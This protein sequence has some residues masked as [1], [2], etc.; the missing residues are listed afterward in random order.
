MGLK[1]QAHPPK[2]PLYT[3]AGD[4]GKTSLFGG[5]RVNK[6]HPR[7]KAYGSL[8]ELSSAL[9]LAAAF[10]RQRRVIGVLRSIQEDL[11]HLGA[12]LASP[13]APPCLLPEDRI[14]ALERLIDRYDAKT[15]PLKR[16]ILPG[17]G[18]AGAALHLARTICRRAERQV[19]ALARQET[20][21]PEVMI[22]LNRLSDLL[23]ALARYVNW[24]EGRPETTWPPGERPPRR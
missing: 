10:V 24:A 7:V 8:D 16:F 13:E 11:F 15:P 22:Y 3:R 23:F 5:Q 17:G 21:R 20:V 12:E 18:P 14:E 1:V 4:D 9:G 6:D 2:S 19:V